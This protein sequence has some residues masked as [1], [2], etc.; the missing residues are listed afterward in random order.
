MD[1]EWGDWPILTALKKGGQ[2]NFY[3]FCL[4]EKDY[5]EE[6]TTPISLENRKMVIQN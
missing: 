1:L 6:F 5:I 3:S 4:K 2:P